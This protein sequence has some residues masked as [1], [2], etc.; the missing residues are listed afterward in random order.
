MYIY[1]QK[2]LSPIRIEQQTREHQIIPIVLDQ[3]L[4]WETDESP[5]YFHTGKVFK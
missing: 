3:R 2:N 5:R 1:R 4:R